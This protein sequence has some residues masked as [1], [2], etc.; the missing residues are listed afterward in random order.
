MLRT[1]IAY[2][3]EHYELTLAYLDESFYIV[4]AGLVS[5]LRAHP[6]ADEVL[7]A[8]VSAQ[9]LHIPLEG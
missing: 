9:L 1:T 7:L 2:Y 8:R 5:Y 3:R 4:I 6:D